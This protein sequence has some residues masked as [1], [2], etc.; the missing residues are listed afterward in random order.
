ME[1]TILINHIHGLDFTIIHAIINEADHFESSIFLS[2]QDQCVNLKS[3]KNCVT[4][5]QQPIFGE[6]TITC[7]GCDNYYALM[8]MTSVLQRYLFNEK[9]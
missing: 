5:F 2:F 6:I 8:R 3:I 4:F 9:C 1:K 7:Y